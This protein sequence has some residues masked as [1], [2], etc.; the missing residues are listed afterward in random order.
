MYRFV[1]D[2]EPIIDVG[3]LA[4]RYGSGSKGV[5]ALRG[6]DLAVT[7]GEV[8]G[9]L[10]P[11]GAGKTTSIRILTGQLTPSAGEAK[12]AGCDVVRQRRELHRRIGVVFDSPNLYDQLTGRQN[13]AFFADLYRVDR[14]RIDA[15]LDQVGLTE[16]ANRRFK[17]YSKG[18][19]QRLILARA[20]LPDPQVLFLDEPTAGLDP[21]SAR[22]VREMIAEVQGRGTTVFLTTHLMELAD[23]VCDRLA[24]LH[25]GRIV[26]EDTPR[27]LKHAHSTPLLV[28]RRDGME[29][30]KLSLQ[31][32][33]TPERTAELLRGGDVLEVA[34]EEATLED[35]FLQI[36]GSALQ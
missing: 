6:I 30:V 33:E 20:L 7:R 13:L 9:F 19:K 25:Q 11:N 22:R 35:V 32:A 36:T 2:S 28:I 14:G 26:A 17:T 5:E 12:V 24:I 8:F 4:R 10:G 18:M 27:A 31:D 23:Q 3:G 21:A 16:A 34:T 15:L 29:P 1:T